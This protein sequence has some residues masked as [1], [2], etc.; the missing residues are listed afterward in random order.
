VSPTRIAKY[1]DVSIDFLR[2]ALVCA[3]VGATAAGKA[4]RGKVDVPGVP[5][6]C[7]D[8]FQ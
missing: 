8:G 3:G 5:W 1:L 7:A 2:M 6:L 4:G